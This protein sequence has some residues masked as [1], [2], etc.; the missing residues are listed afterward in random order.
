M[1][2]LDTDP[3]PEFDF[4]AKSSAPNRLINLL[5]D[6]RNKP[7]FSDITFLVQGRK[8]YAHKIIVVQLSEKFRTMLTAGF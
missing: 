1:F 6:Q 5:A 8:Y 3:C 7:D 4:K 2:E